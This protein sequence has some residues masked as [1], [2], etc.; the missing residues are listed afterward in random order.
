L[1]DLIRAI[2]AL[3]WPVFAFVA[4]FFFRAELRAL[5]NRI[6][7][8]KLMGQELEFEALGAGQ[9]AERKA[10]AALAAATSSKALESAT[11]PPHPA[12]DLEELVTSYDALRA[13]VASGGS[14]NAVAADIIGKMLQAAGRLDS[15]AVEEALVSDSPGRRLAAYAW[16]HEHPD[17]MHAASLV[18]TLTEREP[19]ANGQY[20]AIQALGRV[21][22]RVSA[23]VRSRV[24]LSL[25]KLLLTY[26]P[27]SDRYFALRQLL[28]RP[29]ARLRSTPSDDPYG[30]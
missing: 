13:T 5:L 3:L 17:P 26:P 22:P 18:T 14:R 19:T 27:A 10:D 6:R 23:A 2:A 12:R 15:F 24:E 25:M 7:K 1:A 28:P 20:W 9:S 30:F 11:K 29:E 4:L 21:L 16:L 8:G